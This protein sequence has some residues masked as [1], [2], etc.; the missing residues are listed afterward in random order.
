MLYKFKE[1]RV[2]SNYKTYQTLKKF[3]GQ[4]HTRAHKLAVAARQYRV[5]IYLVNPKNQ[6]SSFWKIAL[7]WAVTQYPIY[8]F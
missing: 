5:S 8:A 4:V 2:E 7:G 6:S 1:Q 3:V